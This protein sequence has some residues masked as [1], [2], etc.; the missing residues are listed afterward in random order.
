MLTKEE[1]E[2][3]KQLKDEVLA[4]KET[5]KRGLTKEE[6]E[7]LKQLKREVE[8]EKKKTDKS[9]SDSFINKASEAIGDTA[10]EGIRQAGRLG[11]AGVRGITSAL[12]LPTT[13]AKMLPESVTNVIGLNAQAKINSQKTLSDL[14]VSENK[15]SAK[16]ITDVATDFIDDITDNKL[17]P[18]GKTEE[19]VDVVSETLLPLLLTGGSSAATKTTQVSKKALD[20]AN[21]VLNF[22]AKA[23]VGTMAS[24]AG[25]A[26]ASKYSIDSDLE[27]GQD[28]KAWKAI[29][30]SLLGGAA[31]GVSASTAKAILTPR[32]TA[33]KITG[34]V[35]GFKPAEY[36]KQQELGLP[37]S[38]G[39]TGS[40]V[41]KK[42]EDIA[43]HIPGSQG[44]IENFRDK[45]TSSLAKKLGAKHPDDLIASDKFQPYHLAKEGAKA[46][47]DKI[48]QNW[49]DA[50]KIY[51]SFIDRAIDQEMKLNV[52]DFITEA[53]E[54]R[55]GLTKPA[56]LADFGK[57]PH[58]MFLEKILEYA[59]GLTQK[60]QKILSE[61]G[62]TPE[63]IN[64]IASGMKD[65]TNVSFAG[66][67]QIIKQVQSKKNEAVRGSPE[68]ADF[69]AI[70][71][72]L[73]N[74]EDN[75]IE[76]NALPHEAKALREQK[77]KYADYA[78]R[79]QSNRKFYVE[80]LLGTDIDVNAFNK[81]LK[82][83]K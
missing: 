45:M 55:R 57:T 35:T 58:G 80:D 64:K 68:H 32:N 48:S 10:S 74:A 30:A 38:L 1:E 63:I 26:A 28:P 49:K 36:A 24:A 13:I 78:S 70:N 62:F 40:G 12:D 15:P 79:D 83:H 16:S 67:K 46:T 17:R 73:R 52:K 2:E 51:K 19:Y 25:A 44:K 8:E 69:T 59:G 9:T 77:A 5:Q 34:R 4:E 29:A 43:A 42:I 82:N 76:A 66:M 14:I 60:E 27:R 21:K 23:N 81:L 71:K 6:E 41:A 50:E 33:A 18:R 11:R 65:D 31:P 22:G 3:L 37:S 56:E 53:L 75:F 39:S 72:N 20:W 7:E 61:K 54:K 47:K